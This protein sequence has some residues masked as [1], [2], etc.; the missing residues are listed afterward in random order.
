MPLRGIV[1][2][3]RT[4]SYYTRLQELTANNLANV[5][6]DAYKRDRLTARSL[7]GGGHPVPVQQVDLTQGTLRE[8]GRPLDIAIDGAGFLVVGTAAGERLTRAGSLQLD[9]AGRLTDHHGD[10]I[11]GEKGPIA[12]SGAQLEIRGDG[13]VLVDGA[14]VDRLRLVTVPDPTRLLKEGYGRFVSD[15]ATVPPPPATRLR[16]HA[17][18]DANIDPMT[19]MV[20]LVMIQRAYTANV[21]ALRAMD[22]L[23]STITNDVGRVG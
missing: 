9:A 7:E 15:E 23:L 2:T 5:S 12:I 4:L 14:E 20:D 1:N 10:P 18:E 11:L 22:G 17:V 21:D 13:T 19:G 16:Q 8:T 3:A 6:S